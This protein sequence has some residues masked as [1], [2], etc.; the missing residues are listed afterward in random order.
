LEKATHPYDIVNTTETLASS[1][2]KRCC[3]FMLTGAF[4]VISPTYESGGVLGGHLCEYWYCEGRTLRTSETPMTRWRDKLISDVPTFV[5]V[6]QA[7][8]CQN[9]AAIKQASNE[10]YLEAML[11]QSEIW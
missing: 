11:K 5:N 2:P 8:A 1:A 9:A 10:S 3:Q 7:P 6:K 4:A